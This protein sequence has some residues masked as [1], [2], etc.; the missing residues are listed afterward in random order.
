MEAQ[1]ERDAVGVP[2]LSP[3]AWTAL[4]TVQAAYAEAEQNRPRGTPGWVQALTEGQPGVAQAWA[5]AR[6]DT[7][8]AGEID[9]FQAA[10]EKRLGPAA[11]SEATKTT[12]TLREALSPST[13][14]EKAAADQVA[15]GM[16]VVHR[17]RA[18]HARQHE[19]QE[20]RQREQERL[21][22]RQRQGPK[23]GR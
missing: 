2:Q 13:G 18:E 3:Q 1:R 14:C 8:V 12:A 19:R 22:K 4:G 17:G 16:A 20:Q 5:V 6:A 7:S 23:L 15:W 9:R 21:Q 10:A 11:V